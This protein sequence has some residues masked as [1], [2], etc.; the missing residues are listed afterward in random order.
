M[1][2]STH[3]MASIY[4]VASAVLGWWVGVR[5]HMT[6]LGIRSDDGGAPIPRPRHVILATG[7]ALLIAVPFFLVMPRL[8]SPWI[9][10]SIGLPI[11][12]SR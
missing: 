11:S 1:A 9:A 8:G 10:G 4:F 12:I 7:A 3:M 2:A 6:G 5:V